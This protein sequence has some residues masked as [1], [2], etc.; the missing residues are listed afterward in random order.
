MNE[1]SIRCRDGFIVW[2]HSVK[3]NDRILDDKSV[4][5]RINDDIVE[6]EERHTCQDLDINVGGNECLHGEEFV[7]HGEGDIGDALNPKF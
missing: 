4:A 3:W 2:F 5:S 1:G 6:L 7:F